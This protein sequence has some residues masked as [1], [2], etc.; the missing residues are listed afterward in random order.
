G[1]H[2]AQHVAG[3]GFGDGGSGAQ[4]Y[5]GGA[6]AE[7]GAGQTEGGVDCGGSYGFGARAADEQRGISSGE[8]TLGACATGGYGA[9]T[10]GESARA[11]VVAVER[12][13]ATGHRERAL[14]HEVA[15]LGRAAA[16]GGVGGREAGRNGG[17]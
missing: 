17:I 8:Q 2:F 14:L 12:Q 9:A 1:L 13:L 4:R 16:D 3:I 5:G 11:C 15:H 10:G 7:D 6:G